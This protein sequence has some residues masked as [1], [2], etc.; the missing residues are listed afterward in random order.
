M[1]IVDK[2]YTEWAWRTR[3]GVPDINNPEDKAILDKL[4]SEITED[5][6][7]NRSIEQILNELQS[8]GV[9]DAYTLRSIQNTYNSFD[10]GKKTTFNKYFRTLSLNQ[11]NLDII[12]SVY[13]EFF[14]AK[15]SKGMGRGEAMIILGIKDSKSGGTAEKDILV[16]GKTYEVKE[17]SGAEFSLAKDGDINGTEYDTNFTQFKKI[18]SD[19]VLEVVEEKV[20]D[21][22][23]ELLKGVQEYTQKNTTRNQ[24]KGYINS[25]K[26][27]A[28]ILGRV[29][30]DLQDQDLHYINVNGRMNISISADDLEKLVP[31]NKVEIQL[32]EELKDA[33]RHIDLLKKHPW[34]TNPGS[35]INQLE[36]IL[37]NFFSKVD[38]MILYGYK[39]DL[40]SPYLASPQESREIFFAHRVTQGIAQAKLK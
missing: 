38:G 19:A 2:L 4:I 30:P 17:L 10:E 33:R 3:T 39:G 5:A 7:K 25:V 16:G 11:S 24:S 14:D 9:K 23:Y 27:S 12:G 36:A 35:N 13:S 18:F 8:A 22:E 28:E 29:L 34:I 31:G 1:S 15:A 21:K 32:G 40:T 37:S 6:A 26:A 20:T